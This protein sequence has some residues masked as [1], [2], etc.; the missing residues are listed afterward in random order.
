MSDDEFTGL[1]LSDLHSGCAGAPS[2]PIEIVQEI[3]PLVIP[4]EKTAPNPIALNRGQQF[5]Y[6]CFCDLQTRIPPKLDFIVI[7]GDPLQGPSKPS[8]A[9]WGNS[10]SS[11]WGQTQIAYALL[12]PLRERT[13]FFWIVLGTPWHDNAYGESLYCL[14]IITFIPIQ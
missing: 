13:D 14:A 4:Q 6:D 12:K 5:L 7:N 9:L 1:V 10:V 3:Q 8:S 11:P 2:A